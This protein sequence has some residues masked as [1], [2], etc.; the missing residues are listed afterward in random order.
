MEPLRTWDVLLIG[1]ASGV[2]KTSVSYRLAQHYG[3]GITE[4]DDFQVILERMTT[5]EQ[6]PILHYW[7]THFDE[8]QRMSEDQQLAFMLKYSQVMATALELVI[9]NHLASNAPIVLEGDFILPSLAAQAAYDAIP[10][11]GRVRAIF[12][13]E[14]DESQIG[15]NYRTREGAAQPKRARASWRHSEWL[16]QEA[17]QLGV[18]AIAAR[19]WETVFQRIIATLAEPL[20]Q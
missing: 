11:A 7:R 19:P 15:H 16:R 2:G 6:Q 17:A 3:V 13:Y 10:A 20:Q 14:D 18:P 9:A 4:V 5:P 8:A 1:G 12:I